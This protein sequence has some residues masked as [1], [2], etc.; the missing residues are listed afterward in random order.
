[1]KIGCLQ[2]KIKQLQ[3]R[4]V[5]TIE[6]E[7]LELQAQKSFEL[8]VFTVQQVDLTEFMQH[9][10]QYLLKCYAYDVLPVNS[11]VRGPEPYFCSEDIHD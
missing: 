4:N 8:E 10:N 11:I 1:M 9:I 7:V 3:G 2:N 5:Q 6:K